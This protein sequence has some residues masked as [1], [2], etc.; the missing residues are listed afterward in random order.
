MALVRIVKEFCPA[1]PSVCVA[2][3]GRTKDFAGCGSRWPTTPTT[4]D[5]IPPGVV[6]EVLSEFDSGKLDT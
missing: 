3:S 5:Y 1:Y 4:P 6:A 2:R